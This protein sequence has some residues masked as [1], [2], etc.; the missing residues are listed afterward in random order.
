VIDAEAP[1]DADG[2]Y[3]IVVSTAADRP[4]NATTG[5]GVAWV[6]WGSTSVNML[7][8]VRHMLPADDFT[9]NVFNV[10]PGQLASE[11]MGE[12]TPVV[13]TCTTAAFEAG[14]AAAC[15]P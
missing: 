1:L 13:S 2:R 12:Y 11:V 4:S 8:A 14:G 9:E 3:T 6:D 7:M 10:A 5:N 15:T